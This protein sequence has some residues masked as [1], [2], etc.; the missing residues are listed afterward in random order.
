MSSLPSTTGIRLAHRRLFF[1]WRAG[2]AALAGLLTTGVRADEIFF[3][4]LQD[5]LTWSA[6]GGR[7]RARVSGTIDAEGYS[8]QQPAPGVIDTGNNTL[9]NPRLSLFLDVQ[10][11]P[12]VY[13]FAQMRADRGFDPGNDPGE[14]R[15]DEYAVRFTPGHDG[16]LTVQ[17]GK[18]ATVVGSWAARHGSWTNPFITAP[19]PYEQLT[20]I[21]DSEGPRSSAQLL[22]WSH[23]RPGLPASVTAMEKYLRLPIIWGPSYA[24]G[25]AIAGAFNRFRYAIEVKHDSLSSRPDAWPSSEGGWNHPTVSG[26]FGF[27]PNE[28]W[29]LGASASAGCYLRPFALLPRSR[30]RGDYRQ[31]VLGHDVTFAWH[32]FQL[33]AE[34]YGARFEVPGIGNADTLAYYAEARYQFSPRFAGAVRWNEQLFGTILDRTTRAHW[35]NGTSRIDVAPVFRLSA[36]VQ[37]KLQYSI[38][39]GDTGTRASNRLAAAQLTVRF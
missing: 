12:H 20:G 7:I 32:H 39:P 25:A 23:V 29:T 26:R 1:R 28:M 16:R 17:V 4:H 5:A 15:L 11:G 37:C 18:F 8:L 9:F 21:W 22:Q 6:D 10:A 27:Q 19:L 33:W 24:T 36:H 3:D 2:I 14:V 35:D 31:L 38:Q 30:S 34:I 13:A